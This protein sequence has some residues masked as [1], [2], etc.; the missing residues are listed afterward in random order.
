VAIEI[1]RKFLIDLQKIPPLK[2]GNI[3]QQGYV[4][5]K[6]SITVRARVSNEKAF[7]TLKGKNRG[8]LRSEF[9]YPIPLKDAL[10]IID[11]L[12][13][14]LIIHKTRYLL[15]HAGHTWEID[16]FEGDNKGLAIAEVE[17]KSEMEIVK[18]PIW[19][20]KEVTGEKKYNNSTLSKHP[21]LL[22]DRD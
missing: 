20:T 8:N 9:E 16:I 2:N 6:N 5:T 15:S 22:W 3:I 11:E 21:Y 12:C 10:E 18:I 13:E 7:L 1:E 19:V 4:E 17:L 14:G